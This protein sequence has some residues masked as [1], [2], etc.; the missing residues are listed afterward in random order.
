MSFPSPPA[1]RQRQG[2]LE[3]APTRHDLP[4]LALLI[5]ASGVL[6]AA[7]FVG[8]IGSDDSSYITEANRVLAT[9][10][11]VPQDH[12]GLRWPLVF[13]LVGVFALVGGSET[14]SVV[15]GFVLFLATLVLTYAVVARLARPPAAM[16]ATVLVAL[17]PLFPVQ[18]TIVN[19]DI[20]E[21]FLVFASLALVLVWADR[22]GRL[23]AAGIGLMIAAGLL[24]GLGFAARPTAGA[25]GFVLGLM[26]LA[27]VGGRRLG[28]ILLGLGFAA[29]VG[30]E[31]LYYASVTG[32]PLHAYSVMFTTHG[33]PDAGISGEVDAGT[34]NITNNRLLGPV[35][36]MLVNQEFSLLFWLAIA[37]G[38]HFAAGLRHHLEPGER[39]L[40]A[41]ALTG[42]V[43]WS[44]VCFYGLGLRPLPRYF[45]APALFAAAAVALWLAA[46]WRAERR[47]VAGLVVLATAGA[48]LLLLDL[49]N[50]NPQIA[51]RTAVETLLADPSTRVCTDPETVRRSRTYLEWQGL[52]P[53][54]LMAV[55]DPAAA[56]DCVLVY[57]DPRASDAMRQ[58][59]AAGTWRPIG[60]VQVGATLMGLVGGPVLEAVGMADGPL[61][62]LIWTTPPVR[63]Y[64]VGA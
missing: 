60:E 53:D 33:T 55:R 30:G 61:R 42:I 8:N 45:A 13:S 31:M 39:R 16:L 4:F 50:K 57:F 25:F 6:A 36:A 18:A 64:R 19:V 49:E 22:D 17:T 3:A 12:W 48:S 41:V 11:Y 14:A 27:N 5:A 35:A 20:Y 54:R 40:V 46:L 58:A 47:V 52:S 63:L 29:V 62:R 44:V 9:G 7:C 34:G 10:A 37:A 28:Y 38:I 21:G 15:P 51:S 23:D 2:L 32:D 24:W 26:F 1:N 56:S 43:V 59:V